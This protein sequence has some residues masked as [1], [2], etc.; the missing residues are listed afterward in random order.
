MLCGRCKP[1]HVLLGSRRSVRTC[2][3]GSAQGSPGRAGQAPREGSALLLRDLQE[4]RAQLWGILQG[5]SIQPSMLTAHTNPISSRT[6]LP[7]IAC[8]PGHPLSSPPPQAAVKAV[9]DQRR[10]ARSLSQ[11]TL[12]PATLS[13]GLSPPP[14]PAAVGLSL[15]GQAAGQASRWLLHPSLRSQWGRTAEREH[16][17]A[18]HHE[19]RQR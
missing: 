18:R 8:P 4:P 17:P 3:Q 15:A 16:C 13:L 9:T 1:Q 12:T 2:C 14:V 6:T 19:R 11:V 7:T 10:E 5:C